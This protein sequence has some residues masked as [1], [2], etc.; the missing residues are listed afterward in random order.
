ML[1]KLAS[2][3]ELASPR[4]LQREV[5]PPFARA[6]RDTEKGGVA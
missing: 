5:A 6:A 3:V 2:A 1:A 4:D